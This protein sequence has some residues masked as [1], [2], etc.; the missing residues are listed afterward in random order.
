MPCGLM[1]N[2]SDRSSVSLPDIVWGRACELSDTRT[3]ASPASPES[4]RIG[5]SHAPDQDLLVCSVRCENLMG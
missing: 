2:D 4:L 5:A 3:G 1:G